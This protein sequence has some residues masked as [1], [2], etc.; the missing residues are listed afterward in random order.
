MSK[1]K[2]PN[3]EQ[4]HIKV[5][6]DQLARALAD[7]DNFR[8]RT[9]R[10]S[11]Q[12]RSIIQA[13]LFS[14]LLPAVDMLMETQK[15][16]Q[17]AG[18]AMTIQEFLRSFK[19]EGIELINVENGVPFDESLHEVVDTV[20]NNELEDGIVVEEVAKGWRIVNGPIIRHAKV[21]VNK[22]NN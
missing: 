14:R 21:K 8:K 10:D 15:H 6:Q 2:E 16:L 20:E 17:E 5:L 22:L 13:Q 3:K 7:Y 19:E 18:L 9:E 4:E 11:E 1:N 12:L